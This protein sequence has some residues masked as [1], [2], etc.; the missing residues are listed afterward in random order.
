MIIIVITNELYYHDSKSIWRWCVAAKVSWL[1]QCLQCV[2]TRIND[3]CDIQTLW[4]DCWEHNSVQTW[5][6]KIIS[7]ITVEWIY[8]DRQKNVTAWRLCPAV[9]NV[10]KM[11][12]MVISLGQNQIKSATVAITLSGLLMGALSASGSRPVKLLWSSLF[13]ELFFNFKLSSVKFPAMISTAL[14]LWLLLSVLLLQLLQ[15]YHDTCQLQMQEIAKV[16]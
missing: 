13:L 4:P 1:E 6:N 9:K 12:C 11:H 3:S 7:C 2:S 15:L 10:I 8:C 14:L 16:D 5:K